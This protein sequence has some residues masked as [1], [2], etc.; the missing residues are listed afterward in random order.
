MI[1]QDKKRSFYHC[2]HCEFVFANSLNFLPPEVKRTRYI[3]A[4]TNAKQAKLLL[5]VQ[6]LSSQLSQLNTGQLT[7][8]NFGRS[9]PDESYDLLASNNH[10]IFNY[11]PFLSEDLGTL[12][13]SYDFVCSY[14][15]IE[16]FANPRKEWLTLSRL[17]K[18]EGW[19]A[20]S[21]KILTNLS[22]F[23]KWHHKNNPTHVSFYQPQTFQFLADLY[24][25]KLLFATDELIL[26]QKTSKSDIKRDLIST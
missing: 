9:L 11:D 23:A 26:M 24:G 19:L 6:A 4:Q 12:R 13:Q 5:F 3:K 25:F 22:G 14:H 17:I 15:V 16:H 8:L 1:V 10:H 21:T 20:I 2:P 7:G 18:P